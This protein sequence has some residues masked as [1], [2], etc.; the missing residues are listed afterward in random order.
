MPGLPLGEPG[1]H[2]TSR[3]VDEPVAQ[4]IKQTV[5]GDVGAFVVGKGDQEVLPD[6]GR[7]GLAIGLERG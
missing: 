7:P 1:S 5:V 2:V 4:T 3:P 6:A